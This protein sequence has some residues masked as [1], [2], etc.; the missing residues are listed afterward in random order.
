M[1]DILIW[2]F[3]SK[4]SR[5]E[6]S[7]TYN[8]NEIC[9]ICCSWW[10]EWKSNSTS[11]QL[12]KDLM[13]RWMQCSTIL[14]CQ[15]ISD[16]KSKHATLRNV[17]LVTM[18]AFRLSLYIFRSILRFVSFKKKKVTLSNH[19]A[20]SICIN[21]KVIYY[22]KDTESKGLFDFHSS[23]FTADCL[24]ICYWWSLDCS[25]IHVRTRHDDA[26]Q[27]SF[28]LDQIVSVSTRFYFFVF[29]M[30]HFLKFDGS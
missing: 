1:R 15:S 21:R 18:S 14:G 10:I 30:F 9:K 19:N 29:S 5:Y 23:I 26:K 20:L 12:L 11:S 27:L 22:K 25:C 6:R 17:G 8:F 3:V 24:I 4:F 7:S 2:L 13:W 28:L 16:K